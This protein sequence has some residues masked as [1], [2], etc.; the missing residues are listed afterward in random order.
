MASL[1]VE[2]RGKQQASEGQEPGSPPGW[3]TDEGANVPEPL[4]LHRVR[5]SEQGPW[6]GNSVTDTEG[7]I[8]VAPGGSQATPARHP[9]GGRKS[10]LKVYPVSSD[11]T[12]TIVLK[13]FWYL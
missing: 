12:N 11:R 8:G 10:G 2:E 3:Q 1:L 9:D 7:G 5:N 6:S 4:C 13:S